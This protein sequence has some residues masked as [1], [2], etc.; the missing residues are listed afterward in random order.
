MT[1]VRYLQL[2]VVAV[3][4][5]AL[6]VAQRTQVIQMARRVGSLNAERDALSE[7][8]RRLFCK[9]SRLS[10]QAAVADRVERMGIELVDPVAMTKASASENSRPS[11]SRPSGRR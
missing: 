1:V 9:I 11:R 5:A 6:V 2:L 3:F 4:F 10:D 8:N 7:E